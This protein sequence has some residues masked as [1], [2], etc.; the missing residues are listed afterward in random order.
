MYDNVKDAAD[1]QL[2]LYG[3]RSLLTSL[4]EASGDRKRSV[5]M[6][7]FESFP[8]SKFLLFGDSGEQDLE[9]YTWITQQRPDQVLGIFIRDVTSGR[10]AQIRKSSLVKGATLPT[11]RRN[12]SYSSVSSRSQYTESLSSE[13]GSLEGHDPNSEEGKALADLYDGRDLTSAQQKVLRRATLWDER[14]AASRS[15]LPKRIPLM[16]FTEP[17]SVE[18]T[19]LELAR[20]AKAES[21]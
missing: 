18:Q 11:P 19:A 8:S 3:S 4:F 12:D 1:M 16:L 15:I 9:L 10:A 13:P 5:V 7:L 2:K 14:V 21:Q 6:G 17:V 20:Q